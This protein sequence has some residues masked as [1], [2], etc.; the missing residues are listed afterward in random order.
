MVELMR[1]WHYGKN[2]LVLVP[3]FF[4]GQLLAAP[5]KLRM[6]LAGF[7]SMCLIASCVYAINDCADAKTDRHHSGKQLRPVASGRVKPAQALILAAIL[8]AAAAAILSLA[9]APLAA[10]ALLACYVAMNVGYSVLGLK[11][12]PVCDVTIIAFGFVLRVLYGALLSQTPASGWLL[13]TVMAGSYYMALGKRR[14]ELQRAQAQAA[15]PVLGRYTQSFL[16]RNM[17]MFLT[18]VIVFYALWSVDAQTVARY[19]HPYTVLSV[20]MVV[21]LSMHYSL[22]VERD[23][24]GDPIEVILHD[25]KLICLGIA[26]VGLMLLLIYAKGAV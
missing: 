2:L 19:G 12:I 7:V 21:L 14:N 15:R 8:A 24:D 22:D 23:A 6:T 26:Y 10:M 16:S 3:L 17:Y 13:L 18:L 25:K 4:S 9:G 11:D 20:P 1:P 5:Q